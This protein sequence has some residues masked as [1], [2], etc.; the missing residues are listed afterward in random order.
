MWL[1]N[2]LALFRTMRTEMHF[3]G[4]TEDERV[5]IDA[6]YVN[7]ALSSESIFSREFAFSIKHRLLEGSCQNNI[8]SSIYL[9]R[10][11][12]VVSLIITRISTWR[13][14]YLSQ[15]TLGHSD[16]LL[17]DLTTDENVAIRHINIIPNSCSPV[18]GRKIAF[19]WYKQAFHLPLRKLILKNKPWFG[20]VFG[21]QRVMLLIWSHLVIHFNL[22]F[23]Q[24]DIDVHLAPITSKVIHSLMKCTLHDILTMWAD[25]HRFKTRLGYIFFCHW[26]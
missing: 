6:F 10:V 19:L 8:L 13:V 23:M 14:C 26:K 7:R 25:N 21:G 3:I 11:F 18:S 22:W 5:A 2:P 12:L 17:F 24:P 15:W 1:L 16:D 4:L 20:V 9:C